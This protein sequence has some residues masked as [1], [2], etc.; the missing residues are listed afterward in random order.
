MLKRLKSFRL[1][2]VFKSFYFIF[3]FCFLV[4]MLFFDSNDF[5]NQFRMSSKLDELQ[6][7]KEYYLEKIEE[8][9]TE[10][11]AFISNPRQLEKFARENYR[12]KKPTE[13]VYIIMDEK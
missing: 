7:E 8:V 2:P 12:M 5:F 1:H 13:D 4:W 10:R 9:K 6:S 11:A 3:G